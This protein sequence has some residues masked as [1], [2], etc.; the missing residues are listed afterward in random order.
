MELFTREK[1]GLQRGHEKAISD[2]NEMLEKSKKV[3]YLFFI[4]LFIYI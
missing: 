1:E 3:L 4:N 2:L